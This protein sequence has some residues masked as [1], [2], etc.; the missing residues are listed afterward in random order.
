[1]STA[2]IDYSQLT[3]FQKI[4]LTTDGTVTDLVS[5]FTGEPIHITKLSQEIVNSQQPAVLQL[6]AATPLLHREILL[7]G[8]QQHY[9]YAVSHFV[10]PRMSRDMQHQLLNTNTPIGL[11]WQQARLETFREVITQAAEPMG[12]LAEYFGG[13][14]SDRLLTRTYLIYH[15]GLPLGVI[16]EKF[17]ADAFPDSWLAGTTANL[18]Q[19]GE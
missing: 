2:P 3:L 18:N 4:L 1:M 14:A 11:L 15:G 8:E 10:I 19:G 7:S 12:Q 17:P 5:L 9:L 16:T 6:D 13:T